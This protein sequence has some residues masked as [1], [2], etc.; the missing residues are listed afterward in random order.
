MKTLHES[1]LVAKVF[2]VYIG[3]RGFNPLTSRPLYTLKTA[4]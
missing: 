2:C 1:G 3:D 4:Y